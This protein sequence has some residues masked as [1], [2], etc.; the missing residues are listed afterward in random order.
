MFIQTLESKYVNTN[1]L[2]TAY[3]AHYT[4]LVLKLFSEQSLNNIVIMLLSCFLSDEG[5]ML[6]MLDHTIR[7]GG[8]PT[9]LY[10]DFVSL[11]CLRRTLRLLLTYLFQLVNKLLTSDD[12]TML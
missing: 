4:F 9:F 6:E 12:Q 1:T 2:Y 8:T 3:A 5:P 10:F 11:L 7:I